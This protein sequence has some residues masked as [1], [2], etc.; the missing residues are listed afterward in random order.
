[1]ILTVHLLTGAA[2]ASKISNPLWVI[3]LAFLSHY[4]LDLLPQAE[5]SI[6]NVR[7]RYW[8]KSFLDF[9]KVFLDVA[10]GILLIF[11]FSK[12]ALLIFIAAFFAI[13]PDG[14]HL[15]AI[16]FPGDRLLTWHQRLHK[17][18][19]YISENKKIPAFWGILS[20]IVVVVITISLL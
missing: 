5:Y 2:I 1:M 18:I 4:F 15:L 17:A 6:K 8:Q 20:Q 3:P 19:N 11:F 14:F 9:F 12:N 16:L 7:E 13:L 10:T